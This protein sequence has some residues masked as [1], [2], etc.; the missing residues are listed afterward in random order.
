MPDTLESIIRAE[1]RFSAIEFLL[2]RCVA[3]IAVGAGKTEQD[4]ES[5]RKQMRETLQ[6]QTFGGLEATT[7]D[8][9]AGALEESVDALIGLLK[10]HMA[11]LKRANQQPGA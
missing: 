1:T 9:V 6:K 5:W 3:A 4:V 7:S 8:A 10:S 11:S 2:C